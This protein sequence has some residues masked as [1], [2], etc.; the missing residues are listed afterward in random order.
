MVNP[1]TLVP[2]ETTVPPG[3]TEQI[4]Y[5]IMKK[6]VMPGRNYVPHV[7]AQY[8]GQTPAGDGGEAG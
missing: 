5:P 2:I 6:Q 4:A 3:T 8:V 7:A 1:E